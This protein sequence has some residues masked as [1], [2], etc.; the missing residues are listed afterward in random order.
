MK[1]TLYRFRFTL[2]RK[3]NKVFLTL[4]DER[5]KKKI[6][7]LDRPVPQVLKDQLLYLNI[8]AF[9]GAKT[10]GTVFIEEQTLM[11]SS[12]KAA[13]RFQANSKALNRRLVNDLIHFHDTTFQNKT[14]LSLLINEEDLTR[15]TKATSNLLKVVEKTVETELMDVVNPVM[16]ETIP[17][18]YKEATD[19]ML[20][21]LS[22]MMELQNKVKDKIR[23]S[24]QLISTITSLSQIAST[25]EKI[26]KFG[27]SVEVLDKI[28]TIYP[29][30]EKMRLIEESLGP[31]FFD[32]VERELT[33]RI[34]KSPSVHMYSSSG[35]S[36]VWYSI[37]A[38]IV[39][40][41]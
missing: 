27:K 28:K 17:E 6:P 7:L 12:Q 3:K 9:N 5:T 31:E 38:L 16:R 33:A 36:W 13:S 15:E 39:A 4:I 25:I 41:D 10:A 23:E 21:K 19:G 22:E 14:L 8:V 37:I 20:A 35:S 34:G 24:H 2:D 1:N 40:L 30:I 26:E 11:E 29:V 32:T 18:N